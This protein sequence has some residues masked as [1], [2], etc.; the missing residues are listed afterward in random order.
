MLLKGKC[1][2]LDLHTR[3]CLIMTGSAVN[4]FL[5]KWIIDL[6]ML[7]STLMLYNIIKD[8]CPESKMIW[9][10]QLNSVLIRLG[11]LLALCRF[12]F[13][14]SR[15]YDILQSI[16]VGIKFNISKNSSDINITYSK[17]NVYKGKFSLRQTEWH[18][19]NFSQII[20]LKC[21]LGPSMEI[22]RQNGSHLLKHLL[23][24]SNSAT[25]EVNE[26]G[27]KNT[28]VQCQ[29]QFSGRNKKTQVSK[30]HFLEC[31]TWVNGRGCGYRMLGA[32]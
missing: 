5:V 4:Q 29:K 11:S 3:V 23:I 30:F 22:N 8:S 12:S 14:I 32:Y 6:P 20:L 27:M 13:S 9:K 21:C 10:G 16:L 17:P 25:Y 26:A 7:C 28:S 18:F 2:N 15:K 24:L 31:Q 1:N 19:F